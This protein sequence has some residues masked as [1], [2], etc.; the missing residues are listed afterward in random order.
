M[1]TASSSRLPPLWHPDVREAGLPLGVVAAGLSHAGHDA[2]SLHLLPTRQEDSQQESVCQEMMSHRPRS[3][4]DG[5]LSHL[6]YMAVR[7]TTA[8]STSIGGTFVRPKL[9]IIADHMRGRPGRQGRKQVLMRTPRG[10]DGCHDLTART[11]PRRSFEARCPFEG[12]GWCRAAARQRTRGGRTAQRR[13]LH[14]HSTTH[15]HLHSHIPLL[16]DWMLACT[17]LDVRLGCVSEY[18]VRLC[19]CSCM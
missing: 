11:T 2:L 6:I 18:S 17:A 3:I 19:T 10:R 12:H 5:C 4:R 15:I 9:S 16:I 14:F 1:L 7:H 8:T 13:E